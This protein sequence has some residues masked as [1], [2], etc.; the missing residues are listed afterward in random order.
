MGVVQDRYGGQRPSPTNREVIAASTT[1]PAI[2]LCKDGTVWA[3]R[4]FDGDEEW[5]ELPRL[6]WK[7]SSGTRI[8]DDARQR[9]ARGG[10]NRVPSDGYMPGR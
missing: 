4:R 9:I 2:V 8:P 3:Y 5:E 6:P 7:Q 1:D 10:S